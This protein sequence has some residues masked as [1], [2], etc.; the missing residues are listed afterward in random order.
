MSKGHKRA[1]TAVAAVGGVEGDVAR[2]LRLRVDLVVDRQI[3]ILVARDA[4][5]HPLV[6]GKERRCPM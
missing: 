5:R 2:P 1:W 4:E 3:A 6:L